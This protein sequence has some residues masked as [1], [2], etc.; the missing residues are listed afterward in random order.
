MK[1]GDLHAHLRCLRITRPDLNDLPDHER[2]GLLLILQPWL[3]EFVAVIGELAPEHAEWWLRVEAM[4]RH[5]F[6][7]GMTAMFEA[8]DAM[9][10]AT[11]TAT[12]SASSCTRG[13]S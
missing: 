9:S 4:A 3:A 13:A 5:Q 7:E 10:T 6:I 11:T 8:E 1:P 12:E 2:V